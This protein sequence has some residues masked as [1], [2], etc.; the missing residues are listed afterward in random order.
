[1]TLVNLLP[2]PPRHR[3]TSWPAWAARVARHPAAYAASAYVWQRVRRARTQAARD[4][5][6]RLGGVLDALHAAHRHAWHPVLATLEHQD[7]AEIQRRGY[8]V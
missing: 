4:R 6:A 5:L 1:M 3:D 8:R 2:R 7:A